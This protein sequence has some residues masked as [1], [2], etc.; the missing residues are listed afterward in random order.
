MRTLV[1]A[2]ALFCAPASAQDLPPE[3]GEAD[4]GLLLVQWDRLPSDEPS[5][6]RRLQ[7]LTRAW[8]G[9]G[10]ESRETFVKDF[11]AF[12]ALH[13]GGAAV[14]GP[15]DLPRYSL[16]ALFP[17]PYRAVITHAYAF[18]RE[19][20]PVEELVQY[21]AEMSPDPSGW[22]GAY[23]YHSGALASKRFIRSLDDHSTP[24]VKDQLIF[25]GDRI[26]IQSYGFTY[27]SGGSALRGYDVRAK[28]RFSRIYVDP[29][30][31]RQVYENGAPLQH[32]L[33]GPT[34]LVH[35]GRGLAEGI[36]RDLTKNLP[37]MPEVS[38]SPPCPS[39][40]LSSHFRDRANRGQGQRGTCHLF[41]TVALLEDAL[42]RAYGTRLTLSEED[43][44]DSLDRLG[45]SVLPLAL[46]LLPLGKIGDSGGNV[47]LDLLVAKAAGVAARASVPYP[48][49]FRER[50]RSQDLEDA[51]RRI[52]REA[53]MEPPRGEPV[54][55]LSVDDERR[56]VRE[57]LKA[58][59]VR[60]PQYYVPGT[61]AVLRRQALM[62]HL[63]AGRPAAVGVDVNGLEGWDDE[64][65]LLPKGHAFL[66]TGFR[67]NE[68]TGEWMF[69]TRNSW[70]GDNPPLRESQLG[71]LLSIDTLDA[72]PTRAP[73]GLAGLT[74]R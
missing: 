69:Q 17:W 18:Q 62:N 48:G 35:E 39:A 43:L 9:R 42:Y 8:L 12:L 7:D 30:T 52:A 16:I 55:T 26:V 71:R 36:A 40:D 46:K 3:L 24:F 74:G 72:A 6:Y 2:G 10:G 28:T 64:K 73:E 67:K 33:D 70:S 22:G 29:A 60:K 61:P 23:G 37:L 50:D 58:I 53:G 47:T 41:A 57:A 20:G 44:S 65:G 32:N 4:G 25:A 1:L 13:G 5:R 27:T 31:W 15:E 21:S 49:E 66:V 51:L 19:G 11:A 59:S 63:C 54:K 14:A 45:K 34:I 68:F 38:W 56:I